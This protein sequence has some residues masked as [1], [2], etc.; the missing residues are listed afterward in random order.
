MRRYTLLMTGR[1]PVESLTAFPWNRWPD[2]NGITGRIDV[3]FANVKYGTI[4][5]LCL[6]GNSRIFAYQGFHRYFDNED[7][8]KTTI[9]ASGTMRHERSPARP[10]GRAPTSS[11]AILPSFVGARPCGRSVSRATRLCEIFVS[12]NPLRALRVTTL[13]VSVQALTT[14]SL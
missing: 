13:E 10:Q 5:S 12:E 6:N 11:P 4:D 1:I 3:E 2:S 8:C 9:I 14:K 7:F